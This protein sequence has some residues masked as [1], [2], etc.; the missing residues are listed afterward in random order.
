[1]SRLTVFDD[2]RPDQVLSVTD[3]LEDIAATLA[4]IGVT[5]ERW[6]ASE[7]LAADADEA[8]VLQA[9]G[10]DVDRL[11]RRGGYRS[12]DVARVTPDHP[13]REEMRRKFL[14][15]HIHKEDEVRFFVE[16]AGMFYLRADGKLHMTLCEAGDLIS[17]P[18]GIRH[19][20]DMGPAPF[21]TAIRMFTTPDGW[22]AAFTGDPIAE[23]FPKFDAA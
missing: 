6:A 18:G 20:F 15:E 4:G 9:Y 5:F 16:G 3:R 8:A 12:V 1:M 19:W 2:T 11:R 21:F 17:V 23:A 10:A 13:A 22:V 14:A 7:P